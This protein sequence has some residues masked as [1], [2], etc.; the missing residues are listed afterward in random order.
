[1]VVAIEVKRAR[2][3]DRDCAVSFNGSLDVHLP[4]V[5]ASRKRSER[6]S[7]QHRKDKGKSNKQATAAVDRTWHKTSWRSMLPVMHNSLAARNGAIDTATQIHL[8]TARYGPK[9]RVTKP[10][11]KG[12]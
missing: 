1:M 10:A 2:L 6:K 4:D 12:T 8:I 11:A 9:P 5:I 3:E 7:H